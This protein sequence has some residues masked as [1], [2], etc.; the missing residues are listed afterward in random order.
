MS[1]S[2]S[3]S[4]LRNGHLQSLHQF[5][6]C[7]GCYAAPMLIVKLNFNSRVQDCR[8][9]ALLPYSFINNLLI[10]L[11]GFIIFDSLK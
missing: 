6:A 5:K 4:Q 3:T 10:D 8:L 9:G 2:L 11:E 1:L 7:F